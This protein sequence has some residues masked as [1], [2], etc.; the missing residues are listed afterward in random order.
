[1]LLII[2]GISFIIA[3]ATIMVKCLGFVVKGLVKVMI[4]MLYFLIILF[5]ISSCCVILG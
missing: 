4:W 5:C 3:L 2:L 1:M